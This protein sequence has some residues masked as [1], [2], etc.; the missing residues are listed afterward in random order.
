M[1]AETD[2]TLG[3]RGELEALARI[4]RRLPAS[5]SADLGPGDDSAVVRAPD[6][7]FAVSTDLLV[8]GPDFRLAWSSFFDLGWKAAAS[9]LADIA[10][11]GGRP[12]ALVVALAA[13]LDTEVTDLEALADGL[14]EGCAAL[15][16][17]CGVVG[18]DLSASDTLT[19]A[20]TV[21]GDL[22][23]RSPVLR[24][25][26]RIGDDVAVAGDLGLAAAG[27]RLLFEDAVDVD[28]APDRDL[29]TAL[30]SRRPEP[31]AAQLRP[32]PPI[33][34]GVAAADAGATAMLDVSD[35]LLLDAR[36]IAR[37]SEASLDFDSALLQPYADRI[38]AL[39]P[40]LADAAM[41]LVLSG[42]EDHSL[43]AAFPAGGVPDGFRVIGRVVEGTDVTVDGA[44][45]AGRAG[46]DPFGDWNG[47]AG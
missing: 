42:G 13:P 32:S 14:R 16:P 35:G 37:A 26:A 25:G 28:G 24:S 4:V 40:E 38:A 39:A 11:M 43:L 19:I 44:S 31:I 23:G 6:G 12:T 46:W 18:G 17:G 7:R 36:R 33:W 20:V 15:A 47:G 27:I 34:R 30:A 10:A 8:H 21:F 2:D 29:F 45:P 3:G 41:G 5:D 9:N 22:G 1:H